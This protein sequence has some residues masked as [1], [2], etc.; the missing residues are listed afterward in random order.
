MALRARMLDS[1]A[2]RLIGALAS[3]SRNRPGAA[4]ADA[5][6]GKIAF[7]SDRGGGDDQVWVMNADGSAQT[8]LTPNTFNNRDPSWS[9]NGRLIASATP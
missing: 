6:A 9:P 4:E 1:I 2:T 7:V 8:S 3:S 5:A